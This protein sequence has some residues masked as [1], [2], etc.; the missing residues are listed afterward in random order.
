MN[1]KLNLMS[2]RG[3]LLGLSFL[4][5]LAYVVFLR[6]EPKQK[7][8][9]SPFA[10]SATLTVGQT[11]QEKQGPAEKAKPSSAASVPPSVE[12]IS[13][14]QALLRGQT[15]DRWLVASRSYLK[16]LSPSQ[17]WDV[18]TS[19]GIADQLQSKAMRSQILRPCVAEIE[20]INTDPNVRKSVVSDA[21]SD[22][23]A[24]G[25]ID[26][27]RSN[28]RSLSSDV[29]F[30]T[31]DYRIPIPDPR[32]LNADQM[33]QEWDLAKGQIRGS[34]DPY[35]VSSAVRHLW[36]TQSPDLLADWSEVEAL[37]SF[38]Q[39]QLMQLVATDLPCAMLSSCGPN[40]PWTIAF[41]ASQPG[42]VCPP[43]SSLDDIAN[44]NFSQVQLD[45]RQRI[46]ARLLQLQK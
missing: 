28:S 13:A 42:M 19:S 20:K 46:L 30:Q 24:V 34:D 32:T 45:L 1:P 15:K 11:A 17:L 8:E 2:W 16:Y 10:T 33:R 6:I 22:L 29:D 9:A 4:V 36:W 26:Y 41:C 25:D 43:G 37:S 40:S 39:D 31:A 7:E 14:A 27:L 23:K 5:V 21:C 18:L 12:S 3:V 44:L 35:L 38:Q